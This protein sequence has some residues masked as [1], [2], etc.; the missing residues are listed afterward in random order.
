MADFESSFMTIRTK[1]QAVL[2]ALPGDTGKLVKTT[3]ACRATVSM[4]IARLRA[5][6]LESADHVY[7]KR[8]KRTT[9]EL[10]PVYAI[11]SFPDAPKPAARTNA[12]YHKRHYKRTR[13]PL[14]IEVRAAR[15]AARDNA[16]QMAKIPQSWAS[17]LIGM[18]A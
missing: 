16:S 18:A 11:G 3:G 15:R 14:E 12:E 1:R 4:W 6:P 9:G 13:R 2:D 5:E 8:W 17:A 10:A 7:V